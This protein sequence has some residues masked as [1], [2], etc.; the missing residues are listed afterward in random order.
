MNED[1]LQYVWEFQLF[2]HRQ[3]NSTKG[4]AVEI[5]HPG[6]IQKN[7]GPDFFNAQVEIDNIKWAGDV[8]IH[9]K[10][11]DWMKHNHQKDPAYN[12]VILHVVWEEDQSIYRREG[13]LI[14]TLELRGRVHKSILDKYLELIKSRT[15]IPC[16]AHIREVPKIYKRQL[17]DQLI[18]ERLQ[19]KSNRIKQI[20]ELNKNDWEATLY[21]LL[22][23]YFGFKV[24]AVPF[25][26]LANALPY[27]IIR[28]YQRNRTQVE[29]LLFG[30]AGFL[31]KTLKGSYPLLLQKEYKFLSNKHQLKPIDLSIWK[32]MRM[33]P[34]NFPT[35][36]L[37]QFASLLS[38]HSSVFQK[39]LESKD[40][41]RLKALFD[42]STHE[43]WQAHYRFD[44]PAGKM[45]QKD[46]GSSSIE[47]L[48]INVILP[49]LYA[50]AE[51][52]GERRSEEMVIDYLKKI[53][54]EGNNSVRKWSL[55]NMPLANACDS[56]A[57]LELKQSRCDLK[58]CL[59]C[60]I[61]NY[62]LNER[63]HD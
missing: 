28:R 43:Y 62:L 33:R 34:S 7:A 8:E 41:D 24:N 57:L 40:L 37:A 59:T 38:M 9:L 42:I 52:H 35:I 12:K 18:V 58:K 55:L 51:L 60:T 25:E 22:A 3:L 49:M 32:F 48:I 36:R 47:I 1:F 4:D 46:L 44:V 5:I 45:Q 26:L 56:Q 11:S 13:S 39:I 29:A 15:W 14:P 19:K 30:Q 27:K 61:G 2:N 21:Q 6:T 23:K 50:Y 16:E 17:M 20:L 10:S 63:N 53:P 31:N 54:K